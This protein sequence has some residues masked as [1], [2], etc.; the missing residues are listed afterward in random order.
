[1][2]SDIAMP[3]TSASPAIARV[4][5]TTSAII[6][7]T[8][9]P[10][11]SDVPRSPV[12]RPPSCEKYCAMRPPDRPASSRSAA[13]CSG[14]TVVASPDC[15]ASAASTGSPGSTRMSRNVTV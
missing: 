12:R 15:T 6:D 8:S 10:V 14:S 1:M 4:P 7:V 13:S 2:M 11:A 9:R 5:G 3:I